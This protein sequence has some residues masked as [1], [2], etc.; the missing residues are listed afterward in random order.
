MPGGTQPNS[1]PSQIASKALE[2]ALKEREERLPPVS[3][4]NDGEA[5]D[6]AMGFVLR[7][8]SNG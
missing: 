5:H 6:A 2:L 7:H 1:K 4:L 8:S 3:L